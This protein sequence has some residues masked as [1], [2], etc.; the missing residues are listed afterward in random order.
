MSRTPQRAPYTD[1]IVNDLKV[2]GDLTAQ[3]QTTQV[4]DI[5]TTDVIVEDADNNE[6]FVLDGDAATPF[7]DMKKNEIRNVQKIKTGGTGS[8]SIVFKDAANSNQNILKLKEGG[9]VEISS[10]DAI[11]DSAKVENIEINTREVYIQTSSP[12]NPD[13]E[14][15]WIDTSDVA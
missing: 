12:S 11:I 9:D 5:V 2:L 6:Q 7:F 13:K 14:D 10:G 8:E 3:G 15:V 4:D 1:N